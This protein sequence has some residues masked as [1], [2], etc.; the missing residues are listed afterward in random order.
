MKIVHQLDA[1]N[2][3]LFDA[4][5]FV[6]D[7]SNCEN[8]V[9]KRNLTS[10]KITLPITFKIIL[11]SVNILIV[12]LCIALVSVVLLSLWFPIRRSLNEVMTSVSAYIL[13]AIDPKEKGTHDDDFDC[14]DLVNKGI[15]SMIVYLL[16]EK[17]YNTYN[18]TIPKLLSI[19]LNF[20]IFFLTSF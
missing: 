15:L 12:R 19:I 14:V 1:L 9:L 20:H 8:L 10:T 4:I 18:R 11:F 17:K 16:P 3:S 7:R 6:D 5:T 2:L 13:N